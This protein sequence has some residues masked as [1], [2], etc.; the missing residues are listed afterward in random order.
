MV[1]FQNKQFKY[2]VKKQA[3]VYKALS[4]S[5]RVEILYLLK[6]GKKCVCEIVEKLE[7]EYSNISRHLSKLKSVGIIES[8]KSGTNIYYQL[9]CPCLLN[10]FSCVNDVIIG[11]IKEDVD[12]IDGKYS[13]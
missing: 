10:F 7:G 9:K 1:D 3:Q 13:P 5:T 6:D 2:L 8:E 11:K 12:L 4:H